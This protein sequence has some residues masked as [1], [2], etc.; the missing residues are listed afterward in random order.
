MYIERIPNRNSP[1]AVLLRESY[2]EGGKV[3]KRTLANLSKLPDEVVDNLKL[4][5]KGATAIKAYQLPENL[6]IIRSLPHGHVSAILKTLKKLGL[7]KIIDGEKS[8]ERSLIEAMIVARII[9]PASKLATARGF[10]ED[11]CTSSIGKVLGIEK[12]HSNELY[13]A[14]DYLLS[15]QTKIESKL[16]QKHLKDGS[17]ILYDVTSTY[18]EGEHCPLAQYGY[19]RDKKKGKAQIIFGL[20]TDKYGRPIA[21]EVFEGNV[22]DNQTLSQQIEK[23][24][25]RFKLN[26]IVWI[27]DRGI[28]TDKN[29]N[30][31]I[32]KKENIDWITAL[33]KTQ[34]RL[35]A[36]KEQIQLG[37]FDQRN[38][39]EI[40]SDLYP[41]ERL[42]VCRNPLVAESNK[43]KRAKLIEKTEEELNKIVLA[44]TRE[45]R[46]L[47]GK[48]KIGLRVGKVINKFKV[49]KYFE[50]DISEERFNYNLKEE[51][52]A[53]EE[54]LDGIYIIRTSVSSEEMDSIS[55]VKNYKSLSKVEFAF[56]CYKTIDLNVRPIYHWKTERV[57]GH[58]FLCMLAYYVEW[59]MKE[60]LKSMLF[61]DEELEVISEENLNFV[62]SKSAKGKKKKKRNKE[63]DKIHSFRT[64]LSDLGTITLNKIRA[65][66]N[67]KEIEF[68][69]V[70]KPTL[71]QEKILKLLGVS[72]YCTQ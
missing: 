71:L 45:K 25:E 68:D 69:K 60:K 63:N 62:I 65:N 58:I 9:N 40:T 37:I 51:V 22:L 48:E 15:K 8:R 18:V 24:K 6:E 27:S 59:H 30:E 35:L 32:K 66:L 56:R 43:I 12:A 52:I 72:L 64:L 61:E 49:A 1:P 21:V 39:I 5:L 7:D 28:L 11:T 17:L 38:L 26:K 42:I 54:K 50:L 33:T 55:T 41:E 36:E 19:N 13:E 34:V 47:K 53:Q 57:K 4:A 29:I 20:I 2:R 23:V 67:G 10:D 31:L 46:K 16:A 14:L 44:T 70:T 3:K